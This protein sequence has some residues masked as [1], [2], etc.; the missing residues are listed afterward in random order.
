MEFLKLVHLIEEPD[1]RHQALSGY[2]GPFSL[3]VGGGVTA[4]CVILEVDKKA[5]APF[6][7]MLKIQGET[8]PLIVRYGFVAPYA[9]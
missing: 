3:G 9:L 8:V 1:L 4:P 2:K 7:R 5:T 6:P